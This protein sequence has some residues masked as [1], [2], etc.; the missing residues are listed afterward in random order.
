[1]KN[2]ILSVLA[3][4]LNVFVFEI[5]FADQTM[6]V[7][8]EVRSTH[9]G[10]IAWKIR[11]GENLT[12]IAERYNLQIK[13][14]LDANQGSKC[15]KTA[16]KI[17]RGCKIAI[18]VKLMPQVIAY[19]QEQEKVLEKAT[20]VARTEGAR[21]S[22]PTILVL[23]FALLALF[24]LFV[25]S[26]MAYGSIKKR[27]QDNKKEKTDLSSKL[28][29]AED[30]IRKMEI[31]KEDFEKMLAY[32]RSELVDTGARVIELNQALATKITAGDNVSVLSK[33]NGKIYL[34]VLKVEL[35]NGIPEV[36]V[37]CSA[38][39][40]DCLSNKNHDL[41]LKNALSHL[42]VHGTSQDLKPNGW[43]E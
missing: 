41:K 20:D 24:L 17:L 37:E 36:Y 4:I 35:E 38:K 26:L 1:M 40:L 19:Q 23:I 21:K 30:K 29:A 39:E 27:M 32:Q 15:I 12:R 16:D 7:V 6:P 14:I 34:K 9:A 25:V 5:V 42:N 22:G 10:P 43:T 31:E 8:P 11:R 28:W 18:P 3:V 2:L 33:N 13:D